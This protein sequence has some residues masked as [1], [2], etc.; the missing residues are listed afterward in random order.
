MPAPKVALT[1]YFCSM[2]KLSPSAVVL[3]GYTTNPG[4]LSWEPLHQI[5][6]TEIYD[7][8]PAA[9]VPERAAEAEILIIN[10]IVLGEVQFDQLPKLRC[11][12]ITATGFDNVDVAAARQRNIVCCNVSGYSTESVAQHVF[13]L[14][15]AL[16]N[17]V[18][19]HNASVQNGDWAAS[20]DFAYTLSPI[21]EW[22]GKTLGIAGYGQIGQR[23]AEIGLA[24]G[25]RI[26]ANRRSKKEGWS[27]PIQFVDIEQLFR[28][29]DI[30]SLHMPLTAETK[31]IVNAQ[32]L[33]M[34]KK[35]ALLI[36]TGRGGLIHEADLKHALQQGT[37]GGAALDVLSQEPPPADHPLIGIKSCLITPHIAWAGVA[38]RQ[39]LLNETI[40][41]VKAFL[42]G[43]LRNEL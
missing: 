39:R 20:P 8:T 2:S 31:H 38:S 40:L 21:P 22:K 27:G 5:C 26:L 15:L 29:S 6:K 25:M 4:D 12:C 18:E 13:A 9:L 24:F 33:A 16:S 41:N 3:D 7:R 34:M 1:H 37:I 35:G 42:D 19:A 23:I 17:R 43:K 30:L 28:E 14:I 10:K 11:I 32:R 36:N